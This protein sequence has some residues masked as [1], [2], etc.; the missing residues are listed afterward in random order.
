M[1]FYLFS[2]KFLVNDLCSVGNHLSNFQHSI[3]IIYLPNSSTSNHL[4][5]FW[6]KHSHW[7]LFQHLE[8][9]IPFLP[10]ISP[11]NQW[12]SPTL[13]CSRRNPLTFPVFISLLRSP[14]LCG[15]LYQ[16][17]YV[18]LSKSIKTIE[19]Q[20][21]NHESYYYVW[22]LSLP[23]L[24][25]IDFTFSWPFSGHQHDPM[26]VAFKQWFCEG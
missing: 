16:W 9:I 19:I 6:Q 11:V 26:F 25:F 2:P 7:L 3:F 15:P 22:F 5:P 10:G 12:S 4:I 20:H 14:Y 8:Y 21:F 13:G 23:W 18:D 24:D 17:S 1:V